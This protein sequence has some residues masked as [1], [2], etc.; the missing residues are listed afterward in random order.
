MTELR[1][2]IQTLPETDLPIHMIGMNWCVGRNGVDVHFYDRKG[3]VG[4]WLLMERPQPGLISLMLGNRDPR[5]RFAGSV[6]VYIECQMQRTAPE[7]LVGKLDAA[8]E[9]LFDIQDRKRH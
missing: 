4:S 3:P 7:D 8:I 1:P 5:D 9:L 6:T 2:V